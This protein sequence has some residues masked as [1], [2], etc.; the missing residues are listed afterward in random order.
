MQYRELGRTGEKVSI[1][2]LGG[3]VVTGLTQAEADA[4][5]AEAIYHGVN[6]IDV[7]PSYG[8]AEERL[9]PALEGK[10]D[11]VYLACKTGQ[12]TREA[13][14][15]ELNRTL[16]R[17]RTDHV[18]AYQ[19]HALDSPE[20][21]ATALGPGGALELF[22]EARAAGKVRFIGITGHIV[23]NLAAA[24]KTG[25]FDTVLFPVNFA[26]FEMAR[27]GPDLL[28]LAGQMNV[29]R[30]AIKAGAQGPWP[31]GED[32]VHPK[33]WYKPI[34]QRDLFQLAVRYALSQDIAAA[35]PPGD[36][37]LFRAAVEV[38]ERFEPID[39]E[40][41]ERLRAASS[42]FSPLFVAKR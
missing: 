10:R 35:L 19:M 36:L 21:L 2:G 41:I 12:R 6:Y 25:R 24:I 15:E 32:H 3:I 40:G 30:L 33:C 20:E 17:L 42:G 26:Q 31:E 38:A 13:A 4:A 14:E 37:E 8:N 34:P 16:S 11:K 9:G 22:E 18:D 7:A 28:R 5:V 23:E 1:I 29:G 39:A 27:F